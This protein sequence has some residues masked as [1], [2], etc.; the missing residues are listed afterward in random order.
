MLN[1]SALKLL[2]WMNAI[3]DWMYYRQIE[4]NCPIFEYRDLKALK[5]GNYIDCLLD[6]ADAVGLTEFDDSA[7]FSQYRI[8]SYGKAYLEFQVSNR[9]KELRNWISL[10]IAAAAFVKSFFLPG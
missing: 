10:L 2:K 9:W 3:D 6:D 8:Q 7:M 4:K 1:K 5:D